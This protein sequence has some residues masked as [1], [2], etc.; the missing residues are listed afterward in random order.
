MAVSWEGVKEVYN[1]GMQV[2]ITKYGH[3]CVLVEAE[4]RGKPRVA[5][6]DP[7]GWSEL[8]L[9]TIGWIDDVF[10]SHIHGDHC[11]PSKLQQIVAKFPDVR[12]TAPTDV[13][14]LLREQ[15]LHQA[16]DVIPAGATPFASPHEEVRPFGAVVPEEIGIHFLGVYTHPGDSHSFAAAMPA[17]ATSGGAVGLYSPR[18]RTCPRTKAKVRFASP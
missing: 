4:E 5:L 14:K 12:I 16:A 18:S 7:G 2:K 13:V 3:S 11:D 8:D 15:G 9:D 1:G 10:V 17:G 6:F